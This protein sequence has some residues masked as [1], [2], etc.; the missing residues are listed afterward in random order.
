[1]VAVFTLVVSAR[2]VYFLPIYPALAV[3]VAWAWSTAPAPGR[4][5]LLVSLVLALASVAAVG[6][7][8]AVAPRRVTVHNIVAVR[9]PALGLVLLGLVA[10][11]GATL[12]ALWRWQRRQAMPLVLGAVALAAL[13]LLET[14]VHTRSV[15]RAFPIREAAARLTARLPAAAEVVYF[16]RKLL[17]ALVFYLPH[18]SSEVRN[19]ADIVGL[20]A[21]PRVHALVLEPEFAWMREAI[22]LP[23]RAI[24]GETIDGTRYLLV[25]FQGIAPPWC[26]G[27]AADAY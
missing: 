9:G 2:E 4:R 10:A 6:V 23:A 7:I 15:A 26:P 17:T 14:Q 19:P 3:L 1:V 22:C 5:W 12:A 21:Q 8:L 11:G 24:G 13:L 18:R 16:D 25:D 20:A 27:T